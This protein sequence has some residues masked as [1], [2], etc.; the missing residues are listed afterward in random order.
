MMGNGGRQSGPWRHSHAG[1][2]LWIAKEEH[3]ALLSEWNS[4][5][6]GSILL[7][8][9][10]AWW[11]SL[12]RADPWPDELNDAVRGPD[13]IPVCHRC[14][15]P[16][17]RPV[18]FCPSCGAAIGPYNNVMPYIDIFSIGEAFRSGV[19]PEAHFTPFRTVA[20]G[21]LGLACYSVLAPLYFLRLNRNYR[22]L[23]EARNG[24]TI[25]PATRNQG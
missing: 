22:R 23:K 13:A 6:L 3:I 1:G 7:S 8:R 9:I 10:R 2:G 19:G 11:L 12:D 18:W 14:L 15:K 20:Y 5:S 24:A 4:K 25:T 21:T 16:C 17:D